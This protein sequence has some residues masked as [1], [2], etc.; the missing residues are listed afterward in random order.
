MS[1]KAPSRT[2]LYVAGALLLI[3]TVVPLLVFTYDSVDPTLGGMPFFFWW[4]FLLIPVAAV[5]T[6]AAYKIISRHEQRH[7][8]EIMREHGEE[9]PR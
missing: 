5:V 7:H 1:E 2:P 8:R 3:P 9:T 6:Y 4:Q